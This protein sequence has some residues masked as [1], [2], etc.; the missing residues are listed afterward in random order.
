MPL[1]LRYYCI[2]FSQIFM[3]RCGDNTHKTV[4]TMISRKINVSSIGDP[5]PLAGML[6]PFTFA[7]FVFLG[8]YILM[9]SLKRGTSRRDACLRED[10]PR[11]INSFSYPFAYPSNY[12]KGESVSSCNGLRAVPWT[13]MVYPYTPER[14]IHN[15]MLQKSGRRQHNGLKRLYLRSTSPWL[16]AISSQGLYVIHRGGRSGVIGHFKRSTSVRFCCIS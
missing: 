13:T 11:Q 8:L 9:R 7:A 14:I 10:Q 15:Q 16:Q 4:H 5:S 3:S 12:E 6:I 2:N 1:R